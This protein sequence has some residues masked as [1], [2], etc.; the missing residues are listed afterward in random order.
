MHATRALRVADLFAGIGGFHLGLRESIGAEVVFAC[1]IDETCRAVYEANFGM[2]PVADIRPVTEGKLVDVPDHDI[3][4]A[5]FPCQPFSKSGKQF[6]IKDTRGTLFYNILRVL[7]ARRPEYVLL[8]N[9]RNLAGPNHRATLATII[10]NLRLL[11][12]RVSDNPTILSPHLLPPE[13]GGRPQVRDRVFILAKYV[14]EGSD[15]DRLIAPPFLARRF[16]LPWDPGNW[17][18]DRYL[19]ADAELTNPNDLALRDSEVEWIQAWNDLVQTLRIERL[20]GFPLWADEFR[21]HPRIH[22]ETP[23][24]KQDF[25]RKNSAFYNENRTEIERWMETHPQLAEFP[26]SRRKFEWQA[27]DAPRD[28]WR[29]VIHLRPSGIRVKR[30]TYLPALVAINQASVIGWKRRRI[31]PREAARLQGFPDDFLL[32]PDAATS[33]RHLGNAVSVGVVS[34]LGRLLVQGAATEE[35]D[36][37]MPLPLAT[38]S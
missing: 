32:H 21:H 5:G 19:Q 36:V 7:E 16:L 22:A 27:Q 28:L 3:L 30:G 38:A 31:S 20:P 9:V 12:Y 4:T 18:I 35:I 33:Y 10:G 26:P 37:Q 13:Q 8:E 23:H 15:A 11:G 1:D 25:L 24:W 29:L 17:S 34:F 6:G 14:G 2:R